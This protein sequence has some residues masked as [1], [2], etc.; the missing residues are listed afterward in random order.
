MASS[1]VGLEKLNKRLDA[2]PRR[3]RDEVHDELE[4]IGKDLKEASQGV[5]PYDQ[6]DLRDAAY[7]RPSKHENGASVEVGYEGLPYI[8]V[9]HEG[10]WRNLVAWGREMGPTRIRN[11]TTPGTGPKFLEAPFAERKAQYKVRIRNAAIRGL[12]E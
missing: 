9:Q 7:S 2:I 8:I 11:Y 12:G 10:G 6:G 4:D 3:V 5:V 1:L